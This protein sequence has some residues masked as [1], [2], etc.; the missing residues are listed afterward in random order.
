MKL[1]ARSVVASAVIGLLSACGGGGGGS[2]SA[3]NP[4]KT[5]SVE[6]AGYVSKSS[7]SSQVEVRVYQADKL[8]T[9]VQLEPSNS[10]FQQSYSL[11]LSNQ[12]ITSDAPL[13]L[14]AYALNDE[15]NNQPRSLAL[16]ASPQPE[17]LLFS[18]QIGTFDQLINADKNQ[19]GYV[20][21][22][23]HLPVTLSALNSLF[24]ELD[25]S[26]QKSAVQLMTDSDREQLMAISAVLHSIYDPS[27]QDP[28]EQLPHHNLSSN[29]WAQLLLRALEG[30]ESPDENW[31]VEASKVYANTALLINTIIQAADELD[32]QDI[33]VPINVDSLLQA[34]ADQPTLDHLESLA[35][36]NQETHQAWLDH[37]QRKSVEMIAV[38]QKNIVRQVLDSSFPTRT[39]T[40]RGQVVQGLIDP[41]VSLQIGAFENNPEY[42]DHYT[43]TRKP[44]RPQI[45]PI[46]AEGGRQTSTEIAANDN[47][48]E[49]TITLR[50]TGFGFENCKPTGLGV[51]VYSPDNDLTKPPTHP[52]D[53]MQDL[54]TV[55]VQDKSS[56]VEMRSYLGAF[57]ELASESVD[58][59]QDGIVTSEELPRLNVSFENAAHA[60]IAE[61]SNL[62]Y[63]GGAQKVKP[64]SQAG[65]AQLFETHVSDEGG[66]G[67][68]E[69]RDS[70]LELTTTL[71]AMQ[72]AS[73]H[74]SSF[75]PVDSAGDFFKS[76]G[77]LMGLDYNADYRMYGKS[78]ILPEPHQVIASLKNITDVA[79]SLYDN[80][81]TVNTLIKQSIALIE[82]QSQFDSDKALAQ[83]V[84]RSI[85]DSTESNWLPAEPIN[86]L[87]SVCVDQFSDDQIRNIYVRGQGEDWVTLEWQDQNSDQ[88]TVHWDS[89]PFSELNSA[90]S[91]TTDEN[92]I[93][94]RGLTKYQ[95]YHFQI[96]HSGTPSVPFPI[97]QGGAGLTNTALFD[98][99]PSC[100]PM[101]G[102]A[103]NSNS[104]GYKALSFLKVN[105]LGDS[106]KRQDLPYSVNPHAC[107][108]ETK[109]G[110]TWAVPNAETIE[111]DR[112]RHWYSIDNRY[113]HG[114]DIT[115]KDDN[116]NGF[117]ADVDGNVFESEKAQFCNTNAIVE[118][119]NEQKLCGISNWRLPNYTELTNILTLS[120]NPRLNFDD[121]FFPNLDNVKLWTSQQNIA[122]SALA[123]TIHPNSW[124]VRAPID[125]RTTPHS[126]MLVSNGL[127]VEEK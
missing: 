44:L 38:D 32:S 53:N 102:K 29:Q 123:H 4:T 25:G 114:N 57:C 117:C 112:I 13:T 73:A 59:N 60:I 41:Y 2:D 40:F 113:L 72:I 8:I 118:R 96:A 10:P 43:D 67:N 48:F 20:T 125:W 16:V 126:L 31:L 24:S 107:T 66:E 105:Q 81:T 78:N 109:S 18:T 7:V 33:D 106:L 124:D 93:T 36:L 27:N 37:I 26:G 61:R 95:N 122:A 83:A 80:D 91:A 22:Q 82:Q 30:V 56:L 11:T 101:T 90:H 71:L 28:S 6:L 17:Q 55:I 42:P 116:F 74:D 63:H 5:R 92:R 49:F 21:S 51:G 98:S 97:Y 86:G 127:E 108:V 100:D 64:V 23:E 9:S 111:G 39:L 1:F 47:E 14:K 54:L 34:L 110:R 68:T 85:S 84:K 3:S 77:Q 115:V 120:G 69:K 62:V 103:R 12:N 46:T 87:E 70:L 58:V 88:Y 15:Q 94:I 76:M 19:D 45:L 52:S 99:D 50:D 119:A 35:T 89:A 121:A 79:H 65:I 75:P 104:D